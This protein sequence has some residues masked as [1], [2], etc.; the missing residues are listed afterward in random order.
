MNSPVWID[1]QALRLLHRESLAEHG[2]LSG[3]REEGLLISALARPQNLFAYEGVTDIP[4]LAAAYAYGI[5][6]NHPFADGNKRAAFL[7]IGLF[8]ALNGYLLQI[9][10]IEAVNTIWALAAGDLDELALTAWIAKYTVE[11]SSN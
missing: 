4:R 1:I 2:G 8:L 6:K 5:T 11:K 9:N 3:M 10:Q 7:C